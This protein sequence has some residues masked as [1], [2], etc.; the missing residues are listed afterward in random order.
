[1]HIK[2]STR[3][4]SLLGNPVKHSYSPYMHNL[5]FESLKLDFAYMAFEIEDNKIKEAIEAMRVLNVKG[6]NITMPYKEEAI[7]FLDA[8]DDEARI[9]GSVNTVLHNNGKLI[10][11]NTDGKG[12]IKAL[13]EKSVDF[14]DKKIVILG[15]GGAAKAIAIQLALDSVKE[16]VIAN[17]TL[18]KAEI[19]VDI[20]KKHIPNVKVKS[21]KLDD[22]L[23]KKELAD[24]TILIN[25][26][27]IGMKDTLGE[28]IIKDVE[29]LH[30]NLL[31]ADTIYNPSK[32]K[33]LSQAEE[34]GCKTMNGLSMLVYQGALAFKIW[35]GRDMP[36]SII[37]DTLKK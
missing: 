23:L 13:E 14:K 31:V 25:T 24:A 11:Y 26:S 2:G 22:K 17:R 28:S 9:I 34:I 8:I 36:K 33:L 20:I 19:I 12:F 29:I 35:T 5:S 21:I 18:V 30:D 16:I 15:S 7:Q 37:E 1:M 27:S 10:G 6:F 32:T 4:I 3:L